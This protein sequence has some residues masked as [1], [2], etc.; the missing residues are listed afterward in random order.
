MQSA[1][2]IQRSKFINGQTLCLSQV[3]VRAEKTQAELAAGKPV[4]SLAKISEQRH[5]HLAKQAPYEIRS[6]VR[7]V[8]EEAHGSIAGT[9]VSYVT[10]D[11]FSLPL[12]I[13]EVP[14]GFE[15]PG[16]QEFRVIGDVA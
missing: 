7:M 13:D 6:D 4:H 12:G 11:D 3:D 5:I 8:L 10:A 16:V 1:A 9:G 15:L 2:F 14:H